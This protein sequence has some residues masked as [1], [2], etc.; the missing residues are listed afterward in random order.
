M[1]VALTRA[2]RRLCVSWARS[3]F[4]FGKTENNAK[5]RFIYEMRGDKPPVRTFASPFTARSEAGTR[6][7]PA[8][9]QKPFSAFV[10]APP[11]RADAPAFSEFRPGVR[12]RHTRFG[13]G[14]VRE[15]MGEGENMTAAIE[16]KGLG[17]KRFALSI[18]IN[19][20]SI[21]KE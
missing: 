17:V 2:K 10:S 13:E 3:R 14:V 21:I 1:Y 20:L 15:T 16:F 9:G 19:S 6:P 12:V 5:S 7:A 11:R 4:R 18:A 8:T